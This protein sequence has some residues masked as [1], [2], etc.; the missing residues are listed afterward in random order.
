MR[1]F[2]K[3]VSKNGNRFSHFPGP[4]GAKKFMQWQFCVIFL[5]FKAL[6]S[7]TDFSTFLNK[8]KGWVLEIGHL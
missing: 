1:D 3:A 8:E 6:C 5:G 4:R 7:K 2:A